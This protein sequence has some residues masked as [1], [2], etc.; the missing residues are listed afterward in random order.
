MDITLNPVSG[1]AQLKPPVTTATAPIDPIPAQ[2]SDTASPV[3]LPFVAA[4]SAENT[5]TTISSDTQ[6]EAIVRQAVLSFKNTYAVS[7]QQIS[8]FKDASGTYITRYVSERDGSVTYMPEPTLVRQLQIANGN[9][10]TPVQLAI[11]A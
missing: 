8:I 1:V 5:S 2:K 7:D 6:R 4:N 11:H 10:D 3:Q 9:S